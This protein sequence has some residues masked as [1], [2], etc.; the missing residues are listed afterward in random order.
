VRNVA[1]N[2]YDSLLLQLQRHLRHAP[3]SPAAH[4]SS[5]C[6]VRERRRRAATSLPSP[7]ARASPPRRG[8]PAES[9]G[10]LRTAATGRSAPL[11]SSA[12]CASG[13]SREVARCRP[14]RPIMII[15][16]CGFRGGWNGMV[17]CE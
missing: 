10:S 15:G 5:A 8:T 9:R 17:A 6:P 11:T 2:E 16:A 3:R 14:P 13:G 12:P 7:Q 1:A 4:R